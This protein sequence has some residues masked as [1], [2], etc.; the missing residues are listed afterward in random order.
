MARHLRILT[1]GALGALFSTAA[2]AQTPLASPTAKLR[3]GLDLVPMPFGSAK[4]HVQGF[5]D[6]SNDTAFAFGIMPTADYLLNQYFFIG[7]APQLSFNIK[8]K[9]ANEA[10]KMLDLLVRVGGNAPIADTVELYGYLAPGYS[11]VFVPNSDNSKGF[12]FGFHGGAIFDLT[13]TAFLNAELGYQIGFQ[14]YQSFDYKLSYF[15]IG[16]GG[17]IRL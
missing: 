12:V 9:D 13:P 11:I 16:L 6:L 2:M 15:Q 5:G 3:L 7:F 17:G 1:L 14:T 8:G 4:A 10:G